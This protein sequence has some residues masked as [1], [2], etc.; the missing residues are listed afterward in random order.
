MGP[1]V[2]V[3]SS[4]AWQSLSAEEQRI[5]REA[6][7]E[8]SRFMRKLWQDWETRSR[9]QA[10]KAGTVIATDVDK[11]PFI[12]AMAELHGQALQD[13]KLRQLVERIRQ[14]P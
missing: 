1:E 12:A 6:A 9:Q 4:R 2:V 7:R 3:M 11:Q 14:T 10:Q 13:D 8:S 5:F